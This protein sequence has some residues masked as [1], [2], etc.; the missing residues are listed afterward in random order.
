MVFD[1]FP[2]EIKQE[3]IKLPIFEFMEDLK[4]GCEDW[5]V[6][7]ELDKLDVDAEVLYRPF[8]TLSFGERKS[9]LQFFFS[10]KMIFC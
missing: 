3:Y 10:G 4:P 5:K 6:M 9:C 7:C 8:E 2:Y 1:Y